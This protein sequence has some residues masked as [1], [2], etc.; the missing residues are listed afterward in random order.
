M[1]VATDVSEN[2]VSSE[3]TLLLSALLYIAH[4][5]LNP[6]PTDNSECRI[7]PEY[8]QLA[9]VIIRNANSVKRRYLV[10]MAGVP[11]SGKT[12]TPH[13]VALQINSIHSASRLLSGH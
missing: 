3:M 8:S 2:D 11:G 7:E 10:A 13:A 12:T 9:N 6:M 4:I 5:Y 1:D